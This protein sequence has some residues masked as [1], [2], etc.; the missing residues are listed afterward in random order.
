MKTMNIQTIRDQRGFTLVELLVYFGLFSILLVVINSMFITTLE[1][2]T[3]DMARS[4]LQQESQ[5]VLAKLKY[6]LYNADEVLVPADPGDVSQSLQFVADGVTQTYQLTNEHLTKTVAGET[7]NVTSNRL[8]VESL[9]FE[10]QSGSAESETIGFAVVMS[11]DQEDGKASSTR[12][13]STSIT[14]R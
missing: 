7:W 3:Q 9:Q 8:Q 6:D 10:N 5:Y 12:T 11:S 13:I 2:Q 4:V 1:Q 14:R